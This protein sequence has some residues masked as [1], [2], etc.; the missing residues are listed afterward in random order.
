MPGGCSQPLQ[1][2][3]AKR[4]RRTAVRRSG[5][6]GS[7][8]MIRASV[9]PLGC[10]S[11]RTYPSQP[12]GRGADPHRRSTISTVC[13]RIV[14]ECVRQVS[15]HYVL[16]RPS[17][18]M[19][20]APSTTNMGWVPLQRIASERLSLVQGLL[21]GDETLDPERWGRLEGWAEALT[22]MLG[23]MEGAEL[24]VEGEAAEAVRDISLLGAAPSPATSAAQPPRGGHAPRVTSGAP[25]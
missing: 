10:C 25:R 5:G 22:W 18:W 17:Q 15:S 9:R 14:A 13:N 8:V 24:A 3:W 20:D 7:A 4:S 6:R 11:I 19:T 1:S 12:G 2:T 21:A 23:L 16:T